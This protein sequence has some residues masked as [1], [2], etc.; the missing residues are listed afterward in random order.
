[1]NGSGNEERDDRVRAG[2]TRFLVVVHVAGGAAATDGWAVS[3]AGVVGQRHHGVMV[4]MSEESFVLLAAAHAGFL[5]R[6]RS[7]RPDR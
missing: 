1:M 4:D 7:V 5:R 2:M 3:R 6:L